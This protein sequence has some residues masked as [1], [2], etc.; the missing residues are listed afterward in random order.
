MKLKQVISMYVLFRESTGRRSTSIAAG[1]KA[2]CRI[3]GNEIDIS[4]VDVGK[5]ADFL[6]GIAPQTRS[7]HHR[8]NTLRAFYQ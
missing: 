7:W 8:H 1:L 5:V 6:T 3:V 4:E 2:F